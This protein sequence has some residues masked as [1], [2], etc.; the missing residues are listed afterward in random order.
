M[1]FDYSTQNVFQKF[2]FVIKFKRKGKDGISINLRFEMIP[3]IESGQLI[4][5]IQ[6]KKDR[7]LFWDEGSNI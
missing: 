1:P 3:K 7:L 6:K 2:V 4:W 5:D